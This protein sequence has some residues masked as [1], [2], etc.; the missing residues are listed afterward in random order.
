LCG[1]THSKIRVA[2]LC[3][4]KQKPNSKDYTEYLTTWR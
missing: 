1:A 4:P 3:Y 2:P